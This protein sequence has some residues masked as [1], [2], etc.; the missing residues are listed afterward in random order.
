MESIRAAAHTLAARTAAAAAAADTARQL[1][2]D[3]LLQLHN[4]SAIYTLPHISS[5]IACSAP[6]ACALWLGIDHQRARGAWVSNF[7]SPLSPP[8]PLPL[9]L[10]FQ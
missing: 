7:S 2:P 10:H 6:Y 9:P 5:A 3:V 1:P 8:P 4:S